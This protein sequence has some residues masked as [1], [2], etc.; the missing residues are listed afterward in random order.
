MNDPN[1]LK[2]TKQVAQPGILFSVAKQPQTT[3]VFTG[4]SDFKIYDLDVMAEKPEPVEYV[5]HESYV[6]GVALC[7]KYLVSGGY[8]GRLIWWDPET[9]QQVRSI[10]AHDKWIREVQA[11]PDGRFVVSV[12]DDMLGRVWDI[13]NGT[14]LRDLSGHALRTPHHF[15]SM[16]YACAI[17]SDG[18]Y[19][20]TGDRVG[21]NVVWDLHNGE[22][23]GTVETP[24]MYTWD[25]KQRIHSIGGV[26]S[27]AFS[28]DAKLLAVGG[29][30]TIG[31]IDHLDAFGRIEIFDW[32]KGERV[33]E[34]VV[35]TRKGLVERMAFDP[36]G[37][38]LVAA[39][40]AHDGFIAFFDLADGKIIKHEKAPMHVHDFVL[41]STADTIYAVGHGQLVVWSVATDL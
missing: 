5:G 23:L 6:T 10:H 28:V 8:D 30:G 21:H 2:I 36:A 33:F 27:L 16:L 12:A 31:N 37:K 39:G 9:R 1:N 40:G 25:P 3:R 18:R 15:P 14:H 35:D 41:N 34:L 24:V 11:T 32:Q 38:W 13:E 22:Q 26:R 29:I 20:A 4:A 19:V 7:G 17:S